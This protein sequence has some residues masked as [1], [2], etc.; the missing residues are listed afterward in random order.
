MVSIHGRDMSNLR[1]SIIRLAH[2][3]PELRKDLLPLLGKTAKVPTEK[4]P[5]DLK[6]MDKEKCCMCR[7]KTDTW[8]K[9]SDRKPGEQVALCEKCAESFSPANI[10]TKQEWMK[11]ERAIG[12]R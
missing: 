3:N 12:N 10:P 1:S 4:E 9:L 5:G 2:S 8:T 7:A 6:G 11:K